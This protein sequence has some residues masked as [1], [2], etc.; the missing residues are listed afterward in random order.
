MRQRDE[1]VAHLVFVVLL[2][3]SDSEIHRK[4]TKQNGRE[5]I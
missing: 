2:L 1:R 5:E 4:K 3:P